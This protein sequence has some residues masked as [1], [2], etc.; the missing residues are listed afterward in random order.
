MSR[1]SMEGRQTSML[2]WLRRLG[3]PVD[4]RLYPLFTEHTPGS[5]SR[6]IPTTLA[7][8]DGKYCPYCGFEMRFNLKKV[9]P[10]RDHKIPRAKGGASLGESNIIVVCRSCN[11][12]KN[13]MT[14]E[15]FAKYLVNERDP[16]AER[17]LR[18]L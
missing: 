10:T 14:L 15:E 9:S 12:D 1:P 2:Q 11:H 5:P 8:W 13:D 3:H 7:L 4:F 16:R 17:V 18:L 6:F